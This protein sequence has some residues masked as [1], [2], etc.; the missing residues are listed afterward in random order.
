MRPSNCKCNQVLIVVFGDNNHTIRGLICLLSNVIG[1]TP[2]GRRFKAKEGHQI[3]IKYVVYFIHFT[4]V[5]L[6][7]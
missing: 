5:E 7:Y 2:K 6:S 1:K 3:V 4:S